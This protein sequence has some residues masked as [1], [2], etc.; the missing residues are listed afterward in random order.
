MA[1]PTRLSL[2]FFISIALT[3]PPTA[4]CSAR[5]V[6][7]VALVGEAADSDGGEPLSFTQFGTATIN[8][9]G[10]VALLARAQKTDLTTADG[11]WSEGG[12]QG[13]RLVGLDGR[14]APGVTGGIYTTM[15]GNFPIINDAGQ[16]LFRARLAT[17][18]GITG[19]NNS[20]VWIAN[21]GQTPTLALREGEQRRVP[22]RERSSQNNRT[23]SA[24]AFRHSTT[25]GRLAG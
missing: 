2:G 8:R 6:R 5:T 25:W 19:T 14:E 23:S 10:D 3:L 9:Y 7:T 12:G 22:R 24:N 1:G 4:P 21:P 16:V 17:A 20:G 18:P 13:L 11:V 15:S